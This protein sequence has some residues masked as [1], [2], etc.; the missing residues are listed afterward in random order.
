MPIISGNSG[1][2]IPVAFLSIF[3][4]YYNGGCSPHYWTHFSS[5]PAG[6]MM[7]AIYKQHLVKGLTRE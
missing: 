6:V 1:G 7:S 3:L 2:A 4:Y 5:L